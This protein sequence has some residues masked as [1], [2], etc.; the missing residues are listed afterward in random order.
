M[1]VTFKQ[2][3]FCVYIYIH[4][5]PVYHLLIQPSLSA[6]ILIIYRRSRRLNL[7][8]ITTRAP[9]PLPRS[10]RPDDAGQLD[11]QWLS[12]TRLRHF[13]VYTSFQLCN[14]DRR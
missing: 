4:T 11:K 6:F 9:S 1:L 8:P 13:S 5:K 14:A 10:I 12:K 2:L 7:T 3:H